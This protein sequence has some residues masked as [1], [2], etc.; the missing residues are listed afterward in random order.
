M[1][2]DGLEKTPEVAPL[3]VRLYDTH[4]LYTLAGEAG[5][6]DAHMELTTVM[7]DLLSIPLSVKESE[8]ITDVMIGLMK[9]AESDLKAGLAE[10]LSALPQIP[11]RMVLALANDEITVADPVLRKSP[12]LDDM[13]LIYIVQAKGVTHARAVACRPSMGEALVD[14]LAEL[15]DVETAINLCENRSVGLSTRAFGIFE[16]MAETDSRIARPLVV[17]HDLPQR[18]AQKLYA[19]VGVDLKRTLA[20]KMGHQADIAIQTLNDVML[21]MVEA[22]VPN[23]DDVMDRYI[24]AA[25]YQMERGELKMPSMIAALRRGQYSTFTGQAVIFFDLSLPVMMAVLKQK[26][27]TSLAVTCKAMDVSKAD[28]ISLYLLTERFR[29]H[30]R[31]VVAHEELSRMMNAYDA[32]DQARALHMLNDSR[33]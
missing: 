28:F 32:I 18:I 19:H 24:A 29:S 12:V 2:F 9:K 25:R 30:T 27:G 11:L 13:D 20:D 17:R 33:G 3:L 5:N 23:D 10:R 22:R 16:K 1:T 6:Q 26:G 14:M 4:N 21:E 8:L 15:H 7:V 31:R